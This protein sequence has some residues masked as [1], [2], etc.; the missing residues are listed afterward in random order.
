[1]L[2]VT[3]MGVTEGSDA[4]VFTDMV[5]D[6]NEILWVL[7]PACDV[8]RYAANHDRFMSAG[9]GSVGTTHRHAK[10]Q[11][12]SLR[13]GEPS[14]ELVDGANQDLEVCVVDGW[15]SF[16]IPIVDGNRGPCSSRCR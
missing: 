3:P 10:S 15:P 11:P 7:L 13:L 1:M 5:L 14:F 16:L 6:L 12:K 2:D 9:I 4:T 8:V